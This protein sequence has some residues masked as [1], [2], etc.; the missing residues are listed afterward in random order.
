VTTTTNK[1]YCKRLISS[2]PLGILKSNKVAFTPALPASHQQSIDNLGVSVFNKVQLSFASPFWDTS[3][4]YI[5]LVS[6]KEHFYRMRAFLNE[7]KYILCAY[8][9]GNSSRY[10][11]SLSDE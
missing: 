2:L 5:L 4:Q 8:V 10:L 3:K 6:D 11:S 9:S 1:Y 7:G